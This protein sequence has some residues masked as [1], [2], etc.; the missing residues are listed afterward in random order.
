MTTD[1][2]AHGVTAYLLMVGHSSYPN[3][4]LCF[5]NNVPLWSESK[6]FEATKPASLERERG[7]KGEGELWK[8]FP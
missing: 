4:V 7:R 2:H 3:Y 1:K 5:P 8:L 6:Q